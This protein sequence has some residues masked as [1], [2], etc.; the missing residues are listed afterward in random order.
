MGNEGQEALAWL[1]FLRFAN[2]Y[3]LRFAPF[4]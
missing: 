2:A 4:L 1:P 3:R